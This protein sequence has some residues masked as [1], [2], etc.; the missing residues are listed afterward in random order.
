MIPIIILAAVWLA[1]PHL[2]EA[3]SLADQTLGRAY[4]HVFVA[5]G[6]AWALVF[7]WAVSIGRRLAAFERE[8]EE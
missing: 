4:W 3:Q 6:V 7:G 5:Y 8:I 2:A 1:T